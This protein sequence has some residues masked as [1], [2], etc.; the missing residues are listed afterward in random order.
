MIPFFIG[1]LTCLNAFFRSRYNLS[2]EILALRQQLGV[3]PSQYAV[4]SQNIDVL[5]SRWRASLIVVKPNTVV[6]WHRTDGSLLSSD[7][8]CRIT[9]SQPIGLWSHPG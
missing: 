1:F 6:R 8:I 9:P 5:V 4:H 2:L 7:D 3:V